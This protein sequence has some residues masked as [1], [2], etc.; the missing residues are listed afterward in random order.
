MTSVLKRST[1]QPNS[2]FMGMRKKQQEINGKKLTA[3]NYARLSYAYE[4]R[5]QMV[6]CFLL[7]TS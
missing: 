4:K 6:K 7:F 3:R 2:L 1:K 5:R